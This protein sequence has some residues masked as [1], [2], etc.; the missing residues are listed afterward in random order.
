MIIIPAID[1]KN[2][3]CVR[4]RQGRM[5]SETVFGEDPAAMALRW[6]AD[7]AEMIHVVDLDGAVE[8]KPR[9]LVSIKRILDAV[10]IPI[11]V[12]GGIRDIETIEM[13][14]SVGIRRIIIGTEAIRNPALVEEA[15]R[16]HPGRIVVGIDA[17]EGLVAIEGWTETTR[18][19]AVELARRFEQSGVAAINFTDIHRDGM[20]TGPNLEATRELAESV[21][22]PVV[23]SGGVSTLRD[24]RNLMP[25][26]PF[27]VIGVI[28]G[29]ALYA[30]TLNLKEAIDLT[31]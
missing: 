9:N 23:A 30:G 10:K 21:S 24:I 11:Q 31:R 14:L 7:G 17:R 4:L 27:G 2:G 16:N 28:T 29:K 6:E 18:I 13:Y 12:G 25:L 26:E 20:Q 5:D 8:K 19:R 1:I 15:C 22:I 3:K